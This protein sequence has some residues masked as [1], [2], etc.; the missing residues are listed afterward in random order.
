MGAGSADLGA[1]FA[2]VVE[3]GAGRAGEVVEDCGLEAAPEPGH[4]GFGG[5]VEGWPPSALWAE[6]GVLR[7][8]LAAFRRGVGSGE[9]SD[10]GEC[11]EERLL[12]QRNL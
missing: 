6:D 12:G 9:V 4:G 3:L 8:S 1:A 7:K 5:V 2:R 10:W 11:V